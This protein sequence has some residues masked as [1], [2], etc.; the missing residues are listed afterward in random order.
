[1]QERGLVA[2]LTSQTERPVSVE[3]RADRWRLRFLSVLVAGVAVVADQVTKNLAVEHL[4]GHAVHLFGSISLALQYNAGTAF[5]LFQGF[6]LWIEVVGI[7]LVCALLAVSRWVRSGVGAVGL[8]MVLGG[9]VGNLADRLFRGNHG[10]VIDFIYTRYWPTFNV[11][12]A[13]IVVG[14]VL[15]ILSSWR[16]K[17]T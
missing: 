11:A 17:A 14:A 2:A 8:G 12:D 7:V 1:M 10:A 4:P 5:S 15:L 16:R 3:P 9:A 13:C 6:G